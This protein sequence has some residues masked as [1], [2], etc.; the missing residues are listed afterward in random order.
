MSELSVS[1]IS[2]HELEAAASLVAESFMTQPADHILA[3]WGANNEKVLKQ[4]RRLFKLLFLTKGK[5]VYVV[6]EGS[7]ILAVYAIQH[8]SDRHMSLLDQARILFPMIKAVGTKLPRLIHWQNQWGRHE[9]KVAHMHLSPMC[10]LPEAQGKGVGTIM[11]KHFCSLL[12]QRSLGAYLE[13]GKW[14]NVLFYQRY[15]FE[16]QEE[17]IVYGAKTWSMWREPILNK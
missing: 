10:V 16:L 5:E 14:E 11:L 2:P 8:S 9:P 1:P 7:K 3:V 13:T 4:N 17:I 15:G 6:K 12:D